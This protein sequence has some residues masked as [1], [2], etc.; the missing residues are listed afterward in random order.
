MTND[1][2]NMEE[3]TYNPLARSKLR[4]NT[5]II[6][7]LTLFRYKSQEVSE[8]FSCEAMAMTV[9]LSSGLRPKEPSL[10]RIFEPHCT[11]ERVRLLGP[12][13]LHDRKCLVYFLLLVKRLILCLCL[14]GHVGQTLFNHLHIY[15]TTHIYD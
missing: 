8:V 6:I 15:V 3:T 4:P 2:F 14:S 1:M 13:P 5:Q 11:S 7:M 10:G 9:V 12:P